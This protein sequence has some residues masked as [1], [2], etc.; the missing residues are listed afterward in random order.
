RLT[1]RRTA[2]LSTDPALL[3]IVTE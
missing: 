3:V 1:V 2:G